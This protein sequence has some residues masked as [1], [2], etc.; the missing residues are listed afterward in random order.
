MGE[1]MVKIKGMFLEGLRLFQNFILIMLPYAL[2]K[3]GNHSRNT[4]IVTLVAVTFLFIIIGKRKIELDKKLIILG[5]VYILTTSLSFWSIR[6][7]YNSEQLKTYTGVII[8]MLFAFSVTQI[9]ID[10]RLYR[11]FPIL[12]SIFSL[13]PAYRALLE[14]H[15]NG[16]SMDYRIFGD[17]WPSVFCMELGMMV[18]ASIVVIFYEKQK[19]FKIISSIALVIGFIAIVGIQAR[20]AIAMIPL[21]F[22]LIAVS[23]NL[24][25]GVKLGIVLLV[26]L[27]VIVSTDFEKYFKRFDS[28]D[29]GG[30]YS[31]QIRVEIYKRSKELI[32]E[33]AVLGIGFYNLRGVN[34]RDEPRLQ[35]YVDIET[36]GIVKEIPGTQENLKLWSYSAT[37][38]H[39]NILETLVTQGV[40]GLISYV[41]F[42]FFVLV[43][44]LK[45]LRNKDFSENR[46]IFVLA[47]I[48]FLYITIDGIIDT[49]IY[50]IKVNQAFFFMMGLALNKRFFV[51]KPEKDGE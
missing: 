5:A 10:K 15:Q 46:E 3:A 19:I 25:I 43:N 12:I 35:E 6:D 1:T 42:L 24:K 21:F 22:I 30:S 44:L 51:R 8:Y 48:A 18:L 32:R 11:W 49:N 4:T 47:F 39:N 29:P 45:N 9:E 34:L 27:L 28:E 36:L 40:L 7:S 16:F 41:C 2:S 13:S 38:L 50:M 20:I 31:N 26:C 23:K 33:N 37:H 14:W 17:S